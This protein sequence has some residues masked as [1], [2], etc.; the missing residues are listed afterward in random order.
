M[1]LYRGRYRWIYGVEN[2]KNIKEN[3]ENVIIVYYVTDSTQ[4]LECAYN[5]CLPNSVAKRVV[6]ISQRQRELF[7]NNSMTIDT[8]RL[9]FSRSLSIILY[10]NFE[11]RGK[12]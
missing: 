2:V 9:L 8:S 11:R 5:D 6:V 1:T 12:K 10:G 7:S 3:Y 4:I